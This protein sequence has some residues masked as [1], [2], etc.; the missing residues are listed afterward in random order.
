M[1]EQYHL[2]AVKPRPECLIGL[3]RGQIA[4]YGRDAMLGE[5]RGEGIMR[6][7]IQSDTACPIR[8]D[9]IGKELH[10]L[11]VERKFSTGICLACV[12]QSP[13]SRRYSRKVFRLLSETA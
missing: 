1:V 12:I 2:A 13:I 11:S 5:R 4:Q 9:G 3:M 10:R 6:K 8:F 7:P